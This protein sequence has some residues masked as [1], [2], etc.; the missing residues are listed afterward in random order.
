MLPETGCDDLG[1]VCFK[2]NLKGHGRIFQFLPMLI[3]VTKF[4]GKNIMA[5]LLLQTKQLMIFSPAQRE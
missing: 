5:M 1:G 3:W 4:L 2:K